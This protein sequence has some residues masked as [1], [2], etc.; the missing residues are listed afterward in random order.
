MA[1][2]QYLKKESTE[3]RMIGANVLKHLE[4]HSQEGTVGYSSLGSR[5]MRVA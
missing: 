4:D 1:N 5:Q 3:I 2:I